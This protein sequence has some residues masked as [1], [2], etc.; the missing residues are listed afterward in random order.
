MYVYVGSDIGEGHSSRGAK[1]TIAM[2]VSWYSIITSTD[3]LYMHV[4]VTMTY[5]Y[6]QCHT[7]YTIIQCRKLRL[8]IIMYLRTSTIAVVF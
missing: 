4:Y 5:M 6:V 7:M 8:S 2:L 3:V 1:I